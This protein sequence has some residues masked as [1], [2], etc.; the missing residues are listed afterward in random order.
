MVSCGNV[1][2][3]RLSGVFCAQ[4][5]S[6]SFLLRFSAHFFSHR[7]FAGLTALKHV[8]KGTN[9]QPANTLRNYL[10]LTVPWKFSVFVYP[11]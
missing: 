8:P 4:I 1:Q 10:S 5:N 6:L 3:D 2:Q 11:N 9:K 7:F